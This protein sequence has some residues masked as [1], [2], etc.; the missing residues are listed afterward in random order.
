MVGFTISLKLLNL[1]QLFIVCE[2]QSSTRYFR[3]LQTVNLPLGLP[4]SLTYHV[5]RQQT[6]TTKL[7][8]QHVIRLSTTH[9]FQYSFCIQDRPHLPCSVVIKLQLPTAGLP[10]AHQHA[11]HTKHYPLHCLLQPLCT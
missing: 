6:F 2:Q 5:R 1:Q 7:T 4:S 11:L 9:A 3:T 8:L 10:H